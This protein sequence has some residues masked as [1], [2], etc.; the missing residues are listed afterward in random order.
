MFASKHSSLP[1]VRVFISRIIRNLLIGFAI[2]ALSL[3]LGMIGYS[4]FEKMN[5]IDAFL[6]AS[7]ILSGMGPVSTLQTNEG[8]IFAGFYAL[9]SGIVFLVII[10]IIIA[11]IFHRFLHK[12]LLKDTN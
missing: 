12:L 7:M 1:S 11:P 2:I 4:Y 3:G 5:W 9:F 6:N 10:A 8:K